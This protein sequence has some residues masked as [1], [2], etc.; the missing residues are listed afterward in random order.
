MWLADDGEPKKRA[1]R[2]Q[3]LVYFN[4]AKRM[5]TKECPELVTVKIFEYLTDEKTAES[6][7]VTSLL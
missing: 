4:S 2:R 6:L 5:T 7:L 1:R 3:I